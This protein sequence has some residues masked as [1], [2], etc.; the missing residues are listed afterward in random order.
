[1]EWLDLIAALGV[2]LAITT[3]SVLI[4]WVISI[5]RH[6]VSTI[7]AVF[8]A[9][10]VAAIAVA[11]GLMGAAPSARARTDRTGTTRDDPRHGDH[12]FR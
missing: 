11:G 2:A 3:G 5:I 4:L 8:S 6:D 1:M 10:V 7:D 9:I 12:R